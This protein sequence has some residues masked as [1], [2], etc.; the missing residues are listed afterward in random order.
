MRFE[1]LAIASDWCAERNRASKVWWHAAGAALNF[2]AFLIQCWTQWLPI[3]LPI[4]GIVA[5]AGVWLF[6]CPRIQSFTSNHFVP[7]ELLA[8]IAASD[9]VPKSVK[10]ALAELAASQGCVTYDNL[11]NA[12]QAVATQVWMAARQQGPGYLAV[13]SFKLPDT[14]DKFDPTAPVV[15]GTHEQPSA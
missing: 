7:D 3:F 11:T 14:T 12:E 2:A 13:L 10:E 9:R 5:T 4:I 6:W 1:S 15:A 8:L